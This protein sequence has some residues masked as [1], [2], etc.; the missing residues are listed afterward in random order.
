MEKLLKQ[1]TKDDLIELITNRLF[2]VEPYH[3]YTILHHKLI[4]KFNT[5]CKK[6]CPVPKD[7]FSSKEYEKYEKEG[8]NIRKQFEKLDKEYERINQTKRR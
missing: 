6:K 8:D 7:L 5:Y 2:I 1:M 4:E 3:I